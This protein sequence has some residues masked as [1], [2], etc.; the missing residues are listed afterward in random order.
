MIPSEAA[1]IVAAGG[2]ELGSAFDINDR[3]TSNRPLGN[4][5]HDKHLFPL[6]WFGAHNKPEL[7]T[8]K[9]EGDG[10]S[11]ESRKSAMEYVRSKCI[12]TTENDEDGAEELWR[13]MRTLNLSEHFS[14]HPPVRADEVEQ[15]TVLC[16]REPTM[17]LATQTPL[18]AMKKE[19]KV[20]LSTR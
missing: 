1:N 14:A 10:V 7:L 13:C 19:A 4:W 5:E 6:N 3:K 20:T 11:L 15:T 12:E 17:G 18:A 16:T 2:C 8:A 9:L